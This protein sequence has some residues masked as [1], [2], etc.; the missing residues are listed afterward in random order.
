MCLSEEK[1]QLSILEL[2]KRSDPHKI[3]VNIIKL[4]FEQRKNS[5]SQQ[6]EY[7]AQIDEGFIGFMCMCQMYIESI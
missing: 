2:L 4:T 3:C 1:Y 5:T 6:I 7:L